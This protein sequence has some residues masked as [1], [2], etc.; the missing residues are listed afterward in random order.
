ML[1]RTHELVRN[2]ANDCLDVVLSRACVHCDRP[3]SLICEPCALLIPP[4]AEQREFHHELWFG[5]SYETTVREMINAHKDHGARALTSDLGLLLA[6]AVWS[7]SVSSSCA[8]PVVLVP[9]PAH[10]SSL[11][12]RGRDTVMEIA[13]D[14]AAQVSVRGIPCV[15]RSLLIRE[16]ETKRNAGRS[17]RERRDI[18]GTFGVRDSRVMP[19]RVIVVDDIVTT[20]ATVNEGVRALIQSGIGVDAI[21]CVASTPLSDQVA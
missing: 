15:A 5:A 13:A 1:V 10:R 20:G 6:R 9:I 7:A 14:A 4:T 8:R 19:S 3:G 18:A 21:A 17:L 12:K 11:R 16:I 2:F